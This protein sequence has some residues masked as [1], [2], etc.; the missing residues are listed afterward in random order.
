MTAGD[1]PAPAR[2]AIELIRNTGAV[3]VE[4]RYS[5]PSE[6][7]EPTDGPV[8]WMAVAQYPGHAGALLA[9]PPGPR[10]R[11]IVDAAL[12]PSGAVLRLA[13]RIIDGG[14]CTH[15][16]RPTV[17]DADPFGAGLLDALGC[18]YRFDP[19]LVRFRRSCEGNPAGN[20]AQRRAGGQ[21]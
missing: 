19:E 17:F 14:E 3:S 21:R 7:P 4:I 15:C 2:A 11:Y 10:W 1:I 13:E 20:R 16:H 6:E 8:V 12:D 18:V 5:D 9:D